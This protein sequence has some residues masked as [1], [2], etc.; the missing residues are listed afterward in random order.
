MQLTADQKKQLL[1]ALRWVPSAH[2]V[3]PL[4][5]RFQ[6]NKIVFYAEPSRFLP[7][8]DP[9]FRDLMISVGASILALDLAL[10]P[11]GMAITCESFDLAKIENLKDRSAEIGFVEIGLAADSAP[12]DLAKNVEK[13]FSYRGRFAKLQPSQ[14]QALQNLSPDLQVVT[15]SRLIS[16]IAKRFDIENVK[17]M[18]S[19]GFIE[20]LFSWMRFS[21]SHSKWSQDGLNTEA[22]GLNA[23]EALGAS[24]IL[25]PSVFHFLAK[26]KVLSLVLTEAPQIQSASAIVLVQCPKGTSRI[27]QGKILYKNWLL[28]TGLDVYGSPM[29]SLADSPEGMAWLRTKT[30]IKDDKE[31]ITAFRTGALPAGYQR[32]QPARLN[33]E[34]FEIKN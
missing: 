34:Q 18:Q 30:A 3:Q 33:W 26:L 15:D 11:M 5:L 24:F 1:Q 7:A 10:R 25:R 16:E 28:W 29:S 32:Y 19:K 9:R 23:I 8:A 21:R 27:E 13:R 12:S 14:I 22:A 4:R 31:I 2:N 20:E 17:G 6:D